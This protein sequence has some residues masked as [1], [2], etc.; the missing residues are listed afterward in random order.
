MK[1]NTKLLIII[2]I[3]LGLG[4]F[5]GFTISGRITRQ[6]IDRMKQKNTPEG[7]YTYFYEM[8]G[9][10]ADQRDTIE[11][12]LREYVKKNFEAQEKGWQDQKVLFREMEKQIDPL[13]SKEQLERK[14]V[15]KEK[16]RKFEQMRNKQLKSNGKDSIPAEPENEVRE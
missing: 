4:I 10:T 3:S 6:K 9:P 8:I 16:F 13:L 11:I 1:M 12:I 14:E 5:I 2:V 15:A 7:L